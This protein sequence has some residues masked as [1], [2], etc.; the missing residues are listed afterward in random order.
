MDPLLDVTTLLV[1]DHDHRPAPKP[2]DAG[3]DGGIVRSTA[4][5]MQL[6][7]VFDETLDVV[8]RVGPLFVTRELDLLPDLVVRRLGRYA[9]E[10]LLQPLELAR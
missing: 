5:A 3:D 1:A 9:L 10:L 6:D 2:A 4:I 7:P 8:E